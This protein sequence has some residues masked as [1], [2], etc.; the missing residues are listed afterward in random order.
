[1]SFP[2]HAVKVGVRRGWTEFVLGMRSPQDWGFYVFMS[3]ITL[4]YLLFNRNTEIEGSD[5][6][7]AAFALPSLIGAIIVFGLVVGPA[8]AI[9]MEREDGTLLRSKAAP[10]GMVGYVIGQVV[11]NS[12]SIIPTIGFILLPSMVLFDGLLHRG[13][14]GWLTLAWVVVLGLLATLPIGIIIGSLADGVQKVGRWSFMPVMVL[15]GISGIFS[16]IQNLWGWLQIVGQSFPMYWV[17]LGLRSAFLPDEAVVFEIGE[18][19]RTLETV[20]VLTAWMILGLV[21]API[22]LRRMARRQSGSAVDAARQSQGQ[23]VR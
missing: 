2:A 10:H 19:W 6:P 16:P 5:L 23:W 11:L 17:A 4:A 1:M 8:Y 21:L 12:A 18:S 3:V 14:A 9:A 20:G 7:F 15:G 13:A 22:V